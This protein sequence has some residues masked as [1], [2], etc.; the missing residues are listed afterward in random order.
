MLNRSLVMAL[1]G[2]VLFSGVALAEEDR[3]AILE[4]IKPIGTVTV[5]GQEPVKVA[6][7]AEPAQAAAVNPMEAKPEAAESKP[8]ETP[9]VAAAPVADAATTYQTACF[10]C[11]GTGA[12]NAPKLGDKVA[13]GP[14]IAKGRD[15]LIHSAL[16]GTAKGMPPKGGQVQLA[17]EVIIAVV[18]YMIQQ[19]E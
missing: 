9:A 11:H 16:N 5:E 10:A 14:R 13:W 4:R 15:A 12:L 3:S 19:G 7:P 2:S 6:E 17:D 18:D 8:A 1:A